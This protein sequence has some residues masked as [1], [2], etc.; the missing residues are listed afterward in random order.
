MRRRGAAW[1]AVGLFASSP[2]AAGEA[3]GAGD[4]ARGA[5]FFAE[6]CVSCHGAGGDVRRWLVRPPGRLE[7]G[8]YRLDAD[9]DGRPGSR[10][11]LRRVLLDGAPRYGGSRL[12]ARFPTLAEDPATL[13]DVLAYLEER[14]RR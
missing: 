7:P 12:M 2:A 1:L 6:H 10:E 5:A 9:G 11:D 14:S 3:G 4:P 13:A 8:A